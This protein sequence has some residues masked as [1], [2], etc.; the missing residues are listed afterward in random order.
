MDWKKSIRCIPLAIG[1]FFVVVASVYLV[2]RLL[3][4][5]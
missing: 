3:V 1:I 4:L 2:S 5:P